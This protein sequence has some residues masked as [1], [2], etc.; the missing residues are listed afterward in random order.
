MNHDDDDDDTPTA[1]A[2]PLTAEDKAAVRAMQNVAQD[3]KATVDDSKVD[4]K[5]V[6]DAL[7]ELARKN[8]EARQRRLLECVNLFVFFF[9]SSL[10]FT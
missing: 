5:K 3:H 8:A 2:K 10:N 7:V 1:A 4:K 9:T 6:S